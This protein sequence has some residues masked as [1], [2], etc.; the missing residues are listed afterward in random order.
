M[1]KYEVARVLEDIATLLEI[2]GEN[3]F[4]IRAYQNAARAVE[5]LDDLEE[6]VRTG[7]LG[8]VK[9]I[10]QAIEA[11]ITTLV[12][13]G[14]LPY[15]Q[16]LKKAVPAG[17][18]ELLRI[19][20]L[21]PKKARLL[22]DR[23]GINTIGEL[24]YACRENRL[25]SLPGFGVKTQERILAGIE[26]L[27][28]F[29]GQF[30]LAD[31]LPTALA[32]VKELEA[33]PAVRQAAVAGSIRRYK[34]VVHDIDLVAEASDPAAVAAWFAARPEVAAVQGQGDTKVAV[35]LHSGV[36]VDLRLV[37][38]GEFPYA[39]HH[40]TG[41]K[42]HNTALRHR[43]RQRDIKVNEYG[44][45]RRDE[46]RIV[47][48]DERAIYQ[49]L[50]LAFIPPELRED[51]GEIEA[52]AAGNLPSLMTLSDIR[53]IFHCHTTASDGSAGLME[54]AAAARQAGYHYL[55]V[56][57]HSQ[58]AAYAHGLKTAD[59][60]AQWREIERLNAAA[61][62]FVILKG[63]ESD[64]LP[65]G[66]L[67]YPDELLGQ[68]DFVIASVHSAFRL[69]QQAMTARVVKAMTN[70]YVTMLGH[71][72]GRILLA[73]D[74]YAIDMD[75]VIRAAAATGTV[76][77]I[78]ANPYRLDLDWR[79]CRPARDAGVLLSINPD[80]HSPAELNYVAYGVAVARK[81]WLTTADV[82]NTRDAT[83]VR[84]L[85]RRKCGG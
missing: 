82:I 47:C 15:Y 30:L 34:E 69:D 4:K 13:T 61:T 76:I 66:S 19:P 18:V 37:A 7:R 53:G 54:M 22:N 23:L 6:R 83:A 85:L 81:G 32:L 55:G 63:I 9:G 74:G 73:R 10:G 41:S 26:F 72:T 64:I 62:D 45:F 16:E 70:R 29:Q 25:V 40:F 33:H 5:M 20:G 52:A 43:A 78:N 2:Q 39:W 36:N 44:L 21:G 80:A 11:K 49:A 12:T 68:F 84:R 71:P 65:D 77:E 67:D 60:K 57:D 48:R 59:V 3:V 35:T 17:V 42:E 75:E 50:G 28:K 51:T 46:S 79:L 24:E 27:K 31:V 58:T 38:A 56:S 8:E 1:D 14:D